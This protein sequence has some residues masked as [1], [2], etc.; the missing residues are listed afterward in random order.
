MT[1]FY[2]YITTNRSGG[3]YIGVTNDLD[4]RIAEHKGGEITGFTQRYNLH[5]L[6]YVEE[7][8]SIREAK[9]REKQ[10]KG[11][12]REKKIALIEAENPEW[13]DLYFERP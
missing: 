1:T 11:W 9:D 10:L 13:R 5:R 6:V 3:L 8:S 4:R 12:R 7:F 2:V